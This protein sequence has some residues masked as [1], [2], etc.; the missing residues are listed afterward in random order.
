MYSFYRILS[1]DLK[2]QS[3]LVMLRVGIFLASGW[4]G[5]AKNG[6]CAL[7]KSSCHP[8]WTPRVLVELPEWWS[9]ELLQPEK[10]R[11]FCCIRKCCRSYSPSP[12]PNYH[13]GVGVIFLYLANLLLLPPPLMDIEMP[14]LLYIPT[15][16]VP[17][18]TR[19]RPTCTVSAPGPCSL[20]LWICP[21]FELLP[22]V[23]KGASM[24][25]VRASPLSL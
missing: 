2:A 25:H 3:T 17:V 19:G 23:C 9:P 11:R 16:S 7:S 24:S 12:C 18:W 1:F 21:M 20:C 10:C 13:W 4:L 22:W 6:S 15:M 14:S 8:N 5:L